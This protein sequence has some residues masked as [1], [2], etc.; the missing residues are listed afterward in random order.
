MKHTILVVIL[1]ILAAVV[2]PACG[3][4]SPILTESPEVETP[5]IKEEVPAASVPETP[6]TTEKTPEASPPEILPSAELPLSSYMPEIPR[7]S[8]EEV[9]AKLDAGSNV[10]IIDS[11]SKASYDRSH[12][13]GAISIPLTDMVEPYDDL[14]SYDKVIFY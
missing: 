7:I 12:I 11:R 9:K 2:L 3:R 8:I 6:S 4:T 5:N 10:I 1:L 14:T 13:A